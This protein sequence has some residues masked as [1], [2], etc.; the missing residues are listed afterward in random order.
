MRHS[1]FPALLPS[2]R[3]LPLG[4]FVGPVGV[5]RLPPSAA[6]CAGA[7]AA[8]APP[9]RKRGIDIGGGVFTAVAPLGAGVG[10]LVSAIDALGVLGVSNL[11][12]TV[13]GLGVG[14]A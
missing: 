5:G 6:S 11:I 4:A 9:A 13:P 2:C 10:C 3:S 1:R 12:M 8:A 7:G 14:R